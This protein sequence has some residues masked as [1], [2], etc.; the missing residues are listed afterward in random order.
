MFTTTGFPCDGAKVG[1]D[2]F[3][4]WQVLNKKACLSSSPRPD[5]Y[6]DTGLGELSSCCLLGTGTAFGAACFGATCVS[7]MSSK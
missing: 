5:V 6:S 4:A 7:C 1:D 3:P 2:G